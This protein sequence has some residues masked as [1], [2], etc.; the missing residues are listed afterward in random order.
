VNSTV[1]SEADNIKHGLHYHCHKPAA[2]THF[3]TDHSAGNCNR[4]VAFARNNRYFL[5]IVSTILVTGKLPSQETT[6]TF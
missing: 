3:T 6:A 2:F 5:I 1:G 4:E